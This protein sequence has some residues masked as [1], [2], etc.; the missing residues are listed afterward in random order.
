MANFE[1]TPVALTIAGSDSSA[2][3]GLQA[4]LKTFAAHAVYGLCAVTAVVA[5]IPGRV[6]GW[7]AMD[8]RLVKQQLDTVVGGFP[9]SAAKTGMLANADIVAVVCDFLENQAGLPVVVDPVM[10]ASSGD[11]LIDDDA[12]A[13]YRERLLPAATLATP[14]LAEAE[15]LLGI[16]IREIDD[17]IAASLEFS[18]RFGC[19]VLIKGGHLAE[20]DRAIDC[21]CESG[22]ATLF[23]GERIPV[24]DTHGT[25]CTLSAAITAALAAEWPLSEAVRE[26]KIYITEAIRRGHE[27]TGADSIR[28]LNHFPDELP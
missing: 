24:A 10:V 14:N 5:E 27:W 3:A 22:H 21:L 28:V 7:E 18:D 19:A 17:M 12:V 8:P 9:I 2:G 25:G 13:L 6:T 15:R 4:D 26:A 16:R 23:E 20:P 11:S 1:S